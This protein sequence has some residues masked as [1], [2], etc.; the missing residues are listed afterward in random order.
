MDSYTKGAVEEYLERHRKSLEELY[1]NPTFP[2]GVVDDIEQHIE[3]RLENVRQSI[4]KDLLTNNAYA[5]LL[6]E[7]E[8]K[9]R[10][11][12]D[13]T[14]YV[15]LTDIAKMKDSK[16]PSY[17]IQGWL[18][19]RNTIEFL[20]LWEREHNRDFYEMGFHKVKRNL[21]DPSFT[22]TAK[23]WKEQT[24]ATGIISKQGNGGGTFAHRDIAIDFYAWVFPKKR[25]ELVKLIAG[26][27]AFFESVQGEINQ[28]K[29]ERPE[30]D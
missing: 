25:Y 13:S 8:A 6:M 26:K 10:K 1:N 29:I 16:N 3:S 19:D 11:L 14:F 20:H 22:L 17:V 24:G 30:E 9:E 4:E 18:R 15:S 2:R 12:D 28:M 27:A 5:T 21:S 23:I 7:L